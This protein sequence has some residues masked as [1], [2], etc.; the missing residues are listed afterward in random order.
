MMIYRKDISE[1]SALRVFER[2]IH[3][4][5]GRGNV[6]LVMSRAG[7]GKT[8]FLVGIALDDAMR[9]R[10]VLHVDTEHS[11]ERVRE[12]YEL[13]FHDLAETM[14]MENRDAVHL[15][16]ERNRMIHSF[17]GGSFG[18]DRLKQ[19]L[20]YMKEHLSFEPSCVILDGFPGWKE[21]GPDELHEQLKEIKALA[22]ETNSEIWLSAQGHRD[23]D[24]DELGVPTRLQPYLEHLSVVVR[25]KSEGTHIRLQLIKDHDNTDL[26]DLHIELDP[27]TLLLK[28]E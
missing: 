7:V 10:K 13:V 25:L 6:G 2:S 19:A 8:A 4:G 28:W 9:E 22:Q 17:L 11:A 24:R 20:G 12:Y 23:D 27:K 14:K 3:G 21:S 16:I 26:A 15:K 18:L 5:L 1:R